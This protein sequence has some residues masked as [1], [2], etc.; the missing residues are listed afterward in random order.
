MVTKDLQPELL[1]YPL[2]PWQHRFRTLSVYCEVDETVLAQRIMKPLEL[3]SNV[4]QITVMHLKALFRPVRT[5]IVRSLR[6]CVLVT[7]PAG[8]GLMHSP[9][10]IRSCRVQGR[11]GA[12]T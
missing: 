4:V 9:A 6:R 8:L 3:I 7:K 5:T 11:F 2:P 12:T 1:P 10:Q